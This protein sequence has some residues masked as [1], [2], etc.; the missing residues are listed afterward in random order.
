MLE[1]HAVRP[2]DAGYLQ[3]YLYKMRHFNEP[4]PG[5]V[6]VAPEDK[7]VFENCVKHLVRL[8]KMSG[9]GKFGLLSWDE[10][11]II[12]RDYPAEVGLFSKA[13]I[14]FLEMIYSA[15][16]TRY[17]FYGEKSLP[18][19]TDRISPNAV[20]KIA[21]SGHYLYKGLP[22]AT[23]EKI[24]QS[25]GPQAMLT[26]G[27]RGVMKQFTLFLQKAHEHD[28]NLSLASRSLAPPGFSFHGISDFDVGQRQFGSDN[29]TERFTTSQVYRKLQALG[30]LDLRYP[31]DNLLGVRFEPWHIKVDPNT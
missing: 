31:R 19:I 20:V 11:L 13:E 14:D 10:G 23:Y 16:A 3:Q 5:D 9:H 24:Q 26:S 7:R 29:F 15:D 28:G 21:N 12:A 4:H 22:L 6:F 2:G 8:E 30:Y 1:P 17:G 27:V 18:N 25:I